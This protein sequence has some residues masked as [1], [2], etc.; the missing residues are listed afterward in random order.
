MREKAANNYSSYIR[1]ADD[2]NPDKPH[3]L[4]LYDTEYIIIKSHYRSSL[5][6]STI[7][8]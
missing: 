2:F 3:N 1:F 7:E 4:K 5:K 8:S 6:L